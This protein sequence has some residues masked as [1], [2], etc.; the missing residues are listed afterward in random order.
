MPDV[1]EKR[2]RRAETLEK[3]WPF[4]A[5]LLRFHRHLWSFQR[6]ILLRLADPTRRGQEPPLALLPNLLELVAREGPPPLAR[7]A[8]SAPDLEDLFRRY[9]DG[10]TIEDPLLEFFP[11]VFLQPA[12]MTSVPPH[13]DGEPVPGGTSPRCP[14]CGDRPQVSVLREDKSAETLRR[15]LICA[16]CSREWDFARVLCPHCREEKPEKLPR[17]TAQEIPWMRVEACDSCGKYLKSVDLTLNWAAEPVVDELA[18]TPLDVIAREHGYVKIV[19][20]LAG[21]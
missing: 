14:D 1:F 19:P 2:I 6:E 21:I 13:R 12:V 10:E 11:R 18:S 8:Q 9:R 4:S 20:N 7:L 15:S 5:E 3:E 16:R 17:Y